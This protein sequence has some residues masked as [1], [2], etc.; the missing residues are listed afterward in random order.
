M[1]VLV[2]QSAPSGPAATPTGRP[3]NGLVTIEMTPAVLMRPS[4]S[5][6]LGV[7][8]WFVNQSAPSEPVV[9]EPGWYSDG[10]VNVVIAPS[11]VMRPMRFVLLLVN[12]RAPSGPL[13]MYPGLT[14][15]SVKSE[16][17]P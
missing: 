16:K 5:P 17:I 8:D 3:I 13:A 9:I 2:T 14:S 10:W 11:T 7:V 6:V 1:I 12:Q 4:E 15:G